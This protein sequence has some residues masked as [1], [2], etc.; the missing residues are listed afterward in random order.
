M[1]HPQRVLTWPQGP[2]L[3]NAV[4]PAHKL[5]KGCS[6]SESTVNGTL[7]AIQFQGA[8]CFGFLANAL[9]Q[10]MSP[11]IMNQVVVS[12]NVVVEVVVSACVLLN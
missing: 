2:S 4:F 7:E 11:E 9:F 1:P 8:R 3:P 12:G 10:K 6:G 5:V